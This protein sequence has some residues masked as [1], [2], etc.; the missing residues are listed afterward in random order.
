M[1]FDYVTFAIDTKRIRTQFDKTQLKL[2][3]VVYVQFSASEEPIAVSARMSEGTIAYSIRWI[4]PSE[5][6]IELTQGFKLRPEF[7]QRIQEEIG[8][9]ISR[10][11]IEAALQVFTNR[12]RKEHFYKTSE[13]GNNPLSLV[14][15]VLER[16][17]LCFRIKQ[18]EVEK[19]LFAYHEPLVSYLYLTCFDRLGQPAEWVDFGSW[20]KSS[21]HKDEREIALSN[22]IQTENVIEVAQTLHSDY[23]ALYG[24]KS[25]F[26]RFLREILP[27]DIYRELLDSIEIDKLKNPPNLEKLPDGN[28]AEREKYLF[29]RR[30]DYTH[31]AD[32]KPP[33]GEWL[34]R[35]YSNHNQEF[36]TEYWTSTRTRNWPEILDKVVRVGLA[37]YLLRAE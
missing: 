7:A 8:E 14:Y 36:H 24:V 35:S 30:N 15:T 5:W 1:N 3:S 12:V 18:P 34:G 19:T 28:D 23:T 31:R 20:L 11:K 13:L 17:D 26:F 27:P 16:L 29:K 4:S 21:R 33:G 22:I 32:F 10:T 37:N 9:Y 6:N 25:S 2:G